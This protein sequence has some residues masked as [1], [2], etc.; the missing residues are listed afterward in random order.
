MNPHYPLSLGTTFTD[1]ALQKEWGGAK[2]KAE[3]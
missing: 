1:W 3:C 2:K